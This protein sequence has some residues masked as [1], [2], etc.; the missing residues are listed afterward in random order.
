MRGCRS[1]AFAC[2]ALVAVVAAQADP[3]YRV[4]AV[5]LLPGATSGEALAVNNKGVVVGRCL[6]D[7]V[8]YGFSYDASPNGSLVDLG[9]LGPGEQHGLWGIN[10]DGWVVGT[11]QIQSSP[12]DRAVLIAPSGTRIDITR[13]TTVEAPMGSV[14]ARSIN[15]LGS[16]AG[17]STFDC[18]F[19]QSTDYGSR[20]SPG[21]FFVTP[22]LGSNYECAPSA[23]FAINDAGTLVGSARMNVGTFTDPVLVDRPFMC[24]DDGQVPLETFSSG[25]ESGTALA[26]SNQGDVCGVAQDLSDSGRVHPVVWIGGDIIRLDGLAGFAE[27]SCALGVNGQVDVVGRSGDEI[28]GEAV[29]WLSGAAQPESLAAL[30]QP[31]AHAPNYRLETATAISDGGFIVGRG[32]GIE[33]EDISGNTVPFILLPCEPVII[34]RPIGQTS[35]LFGAPALTVRAVGAGPLTYQWR[36]NGVPLENGPQAGGSVVSGA[37]TRT[38]LVSGFGYTD[39]G[40]YDVVI[41]GSCGTT[42]TPVVNMHVCRADL[43]CDGIVSDSDFPIFV[44]AYEILDCADPAMPVGCAADFNDDGVVDDEDFVLFVQAYEALFCP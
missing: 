21:G 32:V 17:I 11:V 29:V 2:S 13:A 3:I 26:I 8:Y 43:S 35:C 18:S 22:L 24:D 23:A 15:S 31:A 28:T 27:G 5:P 10:D 40:D 14:Q 39:E 25:L 1:I 44:A 4:M 36:R 16:V 30:A 12:L 6:I 19:T 37:L 34:Q 9:V 33:P 42:I 7:G 38:I 20:W 41:S